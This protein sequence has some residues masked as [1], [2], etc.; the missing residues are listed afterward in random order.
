MGLPRKAVVFEQNPNTIAGVQV[1]TAIYVG[2]GYPTG[3][4]LLK[5]GVTPSRYIVNSLQTAVVVDVLL[6]TL[7]AQEG[8]TFV[9]ERGTGFA[10]STSAYRIRNGG[11]AGT[12]LSSGSGTALSIGR[13]TFDG[14]QWN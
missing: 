13:Y 3:T 4:P 10:T 8:A 2:T 11:T 14:T 9:I 7:N 12:I 1:D 6:D 5:W